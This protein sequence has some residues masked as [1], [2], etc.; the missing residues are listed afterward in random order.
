MNR[1]LDEVA[2]G[3]A[4]T[5]DDVSAVVV[6]AFAGLKTIR[7]EA[8]P[9]EVQTAEPA[10]VTPPAELSQGAA[11]FDGEALLTAF[12]Q[13]PEAQRALLL[14]SL[15]QRMQQP[16]PPSEQQPVAQE[17]SFAQMLKGDP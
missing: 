16:V 14:S 11:G 4:T 9:L 7:T 15:M 12:Q 13:M 5:T 3:H 8:E 17:G 10:V 1:L 2:H 6:T